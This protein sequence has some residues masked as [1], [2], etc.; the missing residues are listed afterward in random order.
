M[1]ANKVSPFKT[2][3]RWSLL[4]MFLLASLLVTVSEG[5]QTSRPR[6]KASYAS[7][8]VAPGDQWKVYVDAESSNPVKFANIWVMIPGRTSTPERIPLEVSKGLKGYLYINTW[9]LG[10]GLKELW[11][12]GVRVLVSFE[13]EMGNRSEPKFFEFSFDYR[14]KPTSPPGAQFPERCLGR[15]SVP[16]LSP[17]GGL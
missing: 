17:A 12:T 16:Y 9:E 10:W 7:S 5:S 1:T 3:F 11:A 4:S 14:A 13:D 6:L 8:S 15:I 2:G